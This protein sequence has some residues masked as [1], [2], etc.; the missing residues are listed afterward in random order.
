MFMIAVHRQPIKAKAFQVHYFMSN[1]PCSCAS[2][3]IMFFVFVLFSY[4]FAQFVI[5][6]T[7]SPYVVVMTD[8]YGL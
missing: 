6:N 7:L 3:P 8:D 5:E 4:K 1:F 2:Y